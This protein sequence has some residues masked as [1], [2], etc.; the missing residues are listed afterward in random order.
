M[1]CGQIH[2]LGTCQSDVDCCVRPMLEEFIEVA[3]GFL[4][5]LQDGFHLGL[6]R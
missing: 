3:N 2:V 1:W 5:Y 6:D 4:I